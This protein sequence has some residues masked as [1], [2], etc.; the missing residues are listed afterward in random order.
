MNITAP[1]DGRPI[2]IVAAGKTKAGK[3]TALNNIFGTNFEVCSSNDIAVRKVQRKGRSYLI[4]D[5]PG[6]GNRSIPDMR[7]RQ[8]LTNAI[9]GLDFTLLFCLPVNSGNIYSEANRNVLINLQNCLHDRMWEK[10]VLLF[11]FSDDLLRKNYDTEKYKQSITKYSITFKK[12]LNSTFDKE[13]IVNS[14]FDYK[15]EYT[16]QYSGIVAV[17]VRKDKDTNTPHSNEFDRNPDIIP[18]IPKTVSW[19]AVAMDEINTKI[20]PLQAKLTAN[21]FRVVVT[22]VGSAIAGAVTVAVG[23]IAVGAVVGAVVGAIAGAGAGTGAVAGAGAGAVAVGV[24]V[25]LPV[26]VDSA[27][28]YRQTI[29]TG[30]SYTAWMRANPDE[31]IKPLIDVDEQI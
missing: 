7:V 18:G 26:A 30:N 10:C 15:G 2:V 1:I 27:F 3:T 23:V 19:T 5:A 22:E 20:A 28:F 6:F 29:R 4:V 16:R 13:Y 31:Q 9:K 24:V 21:N 12:L 14:V 25:V 11:T 17:P 8:L